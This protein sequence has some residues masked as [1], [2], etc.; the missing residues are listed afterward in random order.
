MDGDAFNMVEQQ[1]ADFRVPDAPKELRAMVLGNVQKE[2]RAARWDHRLARAAAVMLVV[3]VGLN[4]ATAWYAGQTQLTATAEGPSRDSLVRTAVIVAEATDAP[5][6]RKYA[7]QVAALRG[8]Q[9]SGEDAA[10]IDA[11]VERATPASAAREHKG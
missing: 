7:R 3:G 4:A 5:T 10:A 11:A 8:R 1:I 6:A 2:L 9:L